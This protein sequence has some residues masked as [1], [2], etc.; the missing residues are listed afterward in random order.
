MAV[1]SA[2]SGGGDPPVWGDTFI[3]SEITEDGISSDKTDRFGEEDYES[4][5]EIVE[6][7]KNTYLI[8]YSSEGFKAEK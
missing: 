4:G 1:L 6:E 7:T 2:M 5:E 8:N 3:N